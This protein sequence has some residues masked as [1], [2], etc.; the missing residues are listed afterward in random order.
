M[1]VSR[2]SLALATLLVLA[3]G[4][5]SAQ[6]KKPASD[7]EGYVPQ[8]VPESKQKKHKKEETQS[9][10][11]SPE[12][13]NIVVAETDKL[14]FDVT[15]LSSK[16]LLTQQTRDAFKNLLRNSRGTIVKLRAFVAGSGDLRRIGELAGEILSDKHQPLPALTVLQVGGLPMPGAQIVIEATEMEKKSVNPNGLAFIS[17]QTAAGIAQ[18][19]D[20]VKRALGAAGLDPSD[21]LRITCFVSSLDEEK[22]GHLLMS[23]NFPNA[24]VNFVQMQREPVTPA[25]ECEAVARLRSAP[26]QPVTFMNPPGLEK[27]P[28]YSQIALVHSAK[29]AITGTQLAFGGQESD[30]KLAFERLEKSLSSHGGSLSRVVMSHVY[31]GSVGIASKVRTVRSAYFNSE[32]PP[33]STMLPF[34]ALPGLDAQM[35][36]DVISVAD[37]SSA[38]R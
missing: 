4:S 38:Q 30:L 7:D 10:P 33:A 1:Y 13:P 12:L 20:R 14:S 27:S 26:T 37:S 31:L 9:L 28:N 2:V 19:L 16:G 6:K 3:A 35:G 15:P 8:V 21:A 25:A 22:S 17:G 11:P 18:S 24:A 36:L 23:G 32:H 29:L 5:V 34:E